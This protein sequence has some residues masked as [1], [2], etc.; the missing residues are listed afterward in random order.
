Q[1]DARADRNDARDLDQVEARISRRAGR[2]SA[3]DDLAETGAEPAA[4]HRRR[5]FSAWRAPRLA[6]R[7]WLDPAFPP[8]AIRRRDRFPAAISANGCRGRA[9]PGRGAGHRMGGP[10]RM[11]TGYSAIATRPWRASS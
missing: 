8:P 7:E 5:R 1:E 4:G 9:R 10:P 11:P 3:D 2:F 6:L